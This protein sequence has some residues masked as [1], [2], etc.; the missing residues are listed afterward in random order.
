MED[1]VRLDDILEN[2]RIHSPE[3]FNHIGKATYQDPDQ[4]GYFKIPVDISGG[5]ASPP[6]PDSIDLEILQGY[7][8]PEREAPLPPFSPEDYRHHLYVSGSNYQPQ[9]DT[10]K[11]VQVTSYK[12]QVWVAKED[13][14][15]LADLRPIMLPDS[16]IPF[17]KGMTVLGENW[18]GLNMD[19][20]D[21][22]TMLHEPVH[23]RSEYVTRLITKHMMDIKKPK[24]FK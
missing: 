11:F 6:E 3:Y 7:Q 13:F 14:T 1:E 4:L 16:F 5:S 12:D 18:M 15:N 19:R 23:R 22:E 21:E 2:L 20:Y 10:Q 24:Y 8:I 17:A 9:Y